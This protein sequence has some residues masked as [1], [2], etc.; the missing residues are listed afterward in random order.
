MRSIRTAALIFFPW[1]VA[2]A[3]DPFV[4]TW[5]MNAEKS[6]FAGI[7]P[8]SMI[9]HFAPHDEGLQYSEESSFIS[10]RRTNTAVFRFDGKEHDGIN[11]EFLA[12]RVRPTDTTIESRLKRKSWDEGTHRLNYTV[13]SD[14][15][16]LTIEIIG[17][18]GRSEFKSTIV[19]ERQP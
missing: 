3:A 1:L 12:V 2:I 15:R 4:G 6:K 18:A 19:L 13:S 9:V 8:Q 17:P 7:G 5:R 11:P 14:G 10:G 16:T